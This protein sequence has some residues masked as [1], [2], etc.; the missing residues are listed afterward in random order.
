MVRSFSG[1]WHDFFFFFKLTSR[2]R[3]YCIRYA[4]TQEGTGS[5]LFCRHPTTW[6]IS[7]VIGHV[8][9]PSLVFL[10]ECLL[11]PRRS[12]WI[13]SA[14]IF[15]LLKHTCLSFMTN[16]VYLEGVCLCLSNL[17]KF[18]TLESARIWKIQGYGSKAMDDHCRIS[19]LY[20]YVQ[21]CTDYN[22]CNLSFF[23]L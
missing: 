1:A 11:Y 17:Q 7:Q 3:K 19:M 22:N 14:I 2:E 4:I 8:K 18:T 10:H 6:T 5:N 20:D 15:V 16:H 13:L 21:S 9:G 23:D 12:I